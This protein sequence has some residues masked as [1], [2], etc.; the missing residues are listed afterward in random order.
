VWTKTLE[1]KDIW[2]VQL[3]NLI[4]VKLQQNRWR[5]VSHDEQR[6]FLNG[7]AYKDGSLLQDGDF[8]SLLQSGVI[9]KDF[10]E[11]LSGEFAFIYSNPEFSIASVDRKRSIPL[12]F[13]QDHSGWN[14]TDHLYADPVQQG[15]DDL[16]LYEYAITGYTA[17]DR[18]LFK[19]VKQVQ[20]GEYV[21]F[22]GQDLHRHTYYKFFHHPEEMSE[23]EAVA[24]L[25]TV[26]HNTFSKLYERVKNQNVMIPL[27]GGYDSRIISLLLKE[28]GATN[29]EAFTYG[30]AGN[31][32]SAKSKEI[33]DRLGFKWT[34]YPYQ[35][36]DWNKWY[37]SEE[38]KK[39][40]MFATNFSSQAHLQDWPAVTE[41]AKGAEEPF[42]FIP[43]H[44]ADFTFG[45]HIPPDLA[46]DR[47]FPIEVVLREIK[48]KHHKLWV[49]SDRE[50][51]DRIDHE[52]LETIKEFPY[53]TN[54]GAS[55]MYEY[56][57]SKER[58]SKFIIH[59]VRAYDYYDQNWEIPLWDDEIMHFILR[60]PLHLRY[61][62]YL[63]D[64]TLHTLYPDFFPKPVKT[65]M[66]S[67]Q[68]TNKQSAVYN[69][70]RK[71]YRKKKLLEQYHKD[72]MEWYGI[73][74]SYKDYLS[75]LS[76][77]LNGHTF[78]NPYNINSFL[79]QEFIKSNV[80][81]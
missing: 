61:K 52:I 23:E 78:K 13:Y 31:P 53:Q 66:A 37:H 28:Q 22:T 43:G 42:T 6:L 30:R 50:V 72:P 44:S 60:V 59:A 21:V 12:F 76:F 73:T 69:L 67:V 41:I 10:A 18:T 2:E 32:E 29:I 70:L 26:L 5:S 39:Y 71:G 75:K 16:A 65:D 74:G 11:R 8:L 49:T 4:Q 56:W 40:E 48:R 36:S 64:L 14:V 46:V 47:E 62:K 80:K 24:Q 54:N 33:A 45:G 38:W 3:S 58:Q 7:Y 77:K 79:V 51:N 15:I 57:N 1:K 9:T 25:S 55:S 34:F 27:S 35:R 81:G 20:A 63:Y 19:G 17:K 68:G